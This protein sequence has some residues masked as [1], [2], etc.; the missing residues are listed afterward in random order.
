MD[1]FKNL[2]QPTIVH[3]G[4]NTEYKI[5]NKYCLNYNI[6]QIYWFQNNSIVLEDGT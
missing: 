3:I 5:S 2:F 6:V 4:E 1:L